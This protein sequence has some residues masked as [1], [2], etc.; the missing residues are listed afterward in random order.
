M[1]AAS[2]LVRTIAVPIALVTTSLAAEGQDFARKLL[3]P[4]AVS[5][6]ALPSCGASQ[7]AAR[8]FGGRQPFQGSLSGAMYGQTF[9][10]GGNAAA[11]RGNSA[12]RSAARAMAQA[13]S[14]GAR[15]SPSA[16][17]IEAPSSVD[18]NQSSASEEALTPSTA[19]TGVGPQTG[20]GFQATEDPVGG[21]APAVTPEPGT[22]LLIGAALGAMAVRRRRRKDRTG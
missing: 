13:G 3:P 14:P 17:P 2:L 19:G 16:D 8:R 7:G 4:S 21:P 6:G 15:P 11:V 5:P 1:I 12:A 10:A 9:F 18:S 20:G 22:L